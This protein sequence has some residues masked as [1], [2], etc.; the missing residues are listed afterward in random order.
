[1]GRLLT[2]LVFAI[3]ATATSASANWQFT[4]WGMSPDQVIAA[5]QGRVA[6]LSDNNSRLMSAGQ[7]IAKLAMPYVSGDLDF[8]AS[9]LF[10]ASNRL[11]EVRLTLKGGTTSALRVALEQK[12]GKLLPHG[13]WHSEDDEII[14]FVIGERSGDVIYRPLKNP[15]SSGL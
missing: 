3:A 8:R 12:Y 5:S 1:M 13:N 6:V 9:F 15:N 14:L 11:A 10:D 2:I 4:K 7:H